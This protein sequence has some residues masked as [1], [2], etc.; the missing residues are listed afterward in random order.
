MNDYN[1]LINQ[2]NLLI[3]FLD[4]SDKQVY[5]KIKNHDRFNLGVTIEQLYK[6]KYLNYSNHIS[7]SALL[8]GFTHIEDF[9]SKCISKILI[10]NP[11]MNK[12]KVEYKT[13]KEKGKSLT[14]YLAKEQAKKYTFSEKINFFER[15][16]PSLNKDLIS[17]LRFATNIRNCLVHNNG[18]ADERLESKYKIGEKIIMNSGEVNGFGLTVRQFA[19]EI[20]AFVK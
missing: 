7:V 2:L 20:W 16:I 10:A 8:L 19:K 18:L 15:N 3:G 14:T 4:V 6:K 12:Y 5:Y 1:Y 9:F 13:I 11:E 17:D